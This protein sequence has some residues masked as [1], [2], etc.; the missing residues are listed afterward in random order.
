[1]FIIRHYL[2]GECWQ[3]SVSSWMFRTLNKYN[4]ILLLQQPLDCIQRHLPPFLIFSTYFFKHPFQF[5]GWSPEG[6]VPS[7]I[8]NQTVF[9]SDSGPSVSSWK[10]K[11]VLAFEKHIM[12]NLN[13]SQNHWGPGLCP[14]SGI[15]NIRKQHFG[16]WICSWPQAKWGR[17]LFCW[18]R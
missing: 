18:V 9:I 16:D 2:Y 17:Q 13:I 5:I 10:L 3:C 14:L 8:S 12:F 7:S 1:L 11:Y 6:P 4:T 15:L